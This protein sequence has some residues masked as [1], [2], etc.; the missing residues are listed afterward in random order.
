MHFIHYVACLILSFV[1]VSYSLTVGGRPRVTKDNFSL[2]MRGDGPLS[3]GETAGPN[4]YYHGQRHL[5]RGMQKVV[6]LAPFLILGSV[7][8]SL[9]PK[10]AFAADD[11]KAFVDALA[12]IIVAKK[13]V[14]P[15]KKYVEKQQFDAARSNIK[16]IL[17]QLQL[18][19]KVTV[20]VRNSIDYCDDMDAV[21]AAQEAGNR[22]AN[23]LIQYDS[24][25]YTCV[26]IPGDDSGALPPNAE[27]YIKQAFGYYDT[28]N[29]DAE[30]LLKVAG[31]KAA[32][33]QAA[34]DKIISNLPPVLFK[35]K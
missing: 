10:S 35:N 6:A 7:S 9:R 5:A 34:A 25:V 28:F 15:T 13:I 11:D 8:S 23:T 1:V 22:I 33:A 31:E 4:D 12:T 24:T 3:P 18:Q 20:L 27:R 17:D 16:Y 30:I 14:E 2:F 21:E 26:F 32:D 19:K 29:S